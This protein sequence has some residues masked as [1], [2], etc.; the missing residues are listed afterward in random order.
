MKCRTDLFLL[1]IMI[2]SSYLFFQIM[3]VSV[4]IISYLQSGQANCDFENREW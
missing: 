3:H 2:Y 1:T 4:Y